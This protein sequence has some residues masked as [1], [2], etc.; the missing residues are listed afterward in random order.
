ML[1]PAHHVNNVIYQHCVLGNIKILD[2]GPCR[3][4]LVRQ[5]KS[6]MGPREVK[7]GVLL[8]LLIENKLHLVFFV[9]L[10]P[11]KKKHLPDQ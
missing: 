2:Q 9:N 11:R 5:Q 7:E 8:I 1:L 6:H 10:V 3:L 4:D